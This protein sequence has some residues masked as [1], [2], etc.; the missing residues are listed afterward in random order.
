MISQNILELAKELGKQ[1]IRVNAICP[2]LVKTKGLV[3]ALEDEYAPA[4]SNIDTFLSE[5]RE[6]QTALNRLPSIEEVAQMVVFLASKNA[7]AITGQCINV[8]CGVLPQ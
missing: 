1:K 5:F 6:K 4:D 8:D 2:V 7:S 3:Q